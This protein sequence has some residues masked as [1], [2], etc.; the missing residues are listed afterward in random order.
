MSSFPFRP[1]AVRTLELQLNARA[2]FSRL[3]LTVF[4][5]REY[6]VLTRT[7]RF[8]NWPTTRR[9]AKLIQQ[10]PESALIAGGV[11]LAGV[12]I[13]SLIVRWFTRPRMAYW[14]QPRDD[15]FATPYAFRLNSSER[16]EAEWPARRR[17]G[18][19]WRPGTL[20]LTNERLGFFPFAWDE[21]PWT[22][23]RKNLALVLGTTPAPPISWGLVD[24]MPDR[25]V[26]Q[27]DEWPESFALLDPE[28]VLARVAGG[29]RL[30]APS[31]A[32]APD[33]HVPQEAFP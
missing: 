16:V 20:V 27:R 12:I 17:Q 14:L 26:C 4:L 18:Q 25:L 33:M 9:I 29:Q 5:V 15:S 28:S 11:A 8:P 21:E 3:A 7:W 13:L 1:A 24:G 31:P 32:P 23:P 6:W 22:A 2:A 10:V 19:S 30:V